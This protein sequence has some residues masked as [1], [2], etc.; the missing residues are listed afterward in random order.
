VTFEEYT[1]R[2]LATASFDPTLGLIYPAL[3]IAG[4]SGEFVD[5]IKKEVRNRGNRFGYDMSTETKLACAKELGDIMW[6]VNQAAAQIGYTLEEIAEINI[7]K[8]EDRKARNVIKSE[9]DNR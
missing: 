4:E 3:G 1:Q 7:Q 8:L 2:A 5:K 9:G 6:Y